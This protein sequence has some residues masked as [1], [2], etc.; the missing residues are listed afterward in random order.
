[1][2]KNIDERVV[3]MQ[4]DNAQFLDGVKGT[5]SGLSSLQNGLSNL[6]NTTALR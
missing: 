4:F 6:G 1:M 5:L 2:S 3:Q